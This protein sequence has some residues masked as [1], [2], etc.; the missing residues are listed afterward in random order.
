MSSCKS[1]PGGWERLDSWGRKYYNPFHWKP[2]SGT[3]VSRQ[4]VDQDL[5]S[6]SSIIHDP[7]IL[8]C[9]KAALD[10]AFHVGL[11]VLK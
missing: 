11:P 7:Q 5:A 10:V 2:K 6:W 1:S 9:V 8:G 3:R 4:V